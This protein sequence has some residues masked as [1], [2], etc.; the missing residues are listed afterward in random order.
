MIEISVSLKSRLTFVLYKKS[1]VI[2]VDKKD[3]INLKNL[4]IHN[5]TIYWSD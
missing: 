1:L 4:L 5:K 2:Y 3:I